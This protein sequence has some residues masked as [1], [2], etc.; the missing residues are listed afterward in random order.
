MSQVSQAHQFQTIRRTLAF[1]GLP[2]PYLAYST[3][4]V[5]PVLCLSFPKKSITRHTWLQWAVGSL[6]FYSGD[7]GLRIELPGTGQM[8]SQ[9]CVHLPP[10][11]PSEDYLKHKASKRLS[12]WE[13]EKGKRAG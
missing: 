13:T 9:D 1:K 7:C 4:D 2:H 11:L 12:E 6:A 8:V 3:T 5:D 10:K